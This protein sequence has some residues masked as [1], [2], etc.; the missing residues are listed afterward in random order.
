MNCHIN[1]LQEFKTHLYPANIPKSFANILRRCFASYIVRCDLHTKHTLFL[2]K[3]YVYLICF[4]PDKLHYTNF[5][6]HSTEKSQ[7]PSALTC[8]SWR[9]NHAK[10]TRWNWLLSRINHYLNLDKSLLWQRGNPEQQIWQ[11]V[12]ATL[13]DSPLILGSQCVF[14]TLRRSIKTALQ[15]WNKAPTFISPYWT[16]YFY[17][18][19]MLTEP[20]KILRTSN[21]AAYPFKP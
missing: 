9:A 7:K 10:L 1:Y 16:R 13:I 17:S 12:N 15:K 21:C 14:H 4:F 3:P 20:L 8:R 6:K 11:Q 18:L 2:C 19:V 5:N